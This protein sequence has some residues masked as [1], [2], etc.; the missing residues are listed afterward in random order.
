MQTHIQ[1]PTHIA[2][3]LGDYYYPEDYS[4]T[5]NSLIFDRYANSVM[6]SCLSKLIGVEV[7]GIR[8]RG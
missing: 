8:D 6:R 3:N 2:P 5:G 1:T 4:T 7:R